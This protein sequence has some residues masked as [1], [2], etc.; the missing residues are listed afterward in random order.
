MDTGTLGPRG[1][2]VLLPTPNPPTNL[3][4]LRVEEELDLP[5]S[6]V[7]GPTVGPDPSRLEIRPSISVSVSPPSPRPL[8]STSEGFP[9]PGVNNLWMTRVLESV[10]FKSGICTKETE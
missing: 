10:Q 3:N 6:R 9:F 1:P 8:T 5:R 7:Q 2:S 4:P